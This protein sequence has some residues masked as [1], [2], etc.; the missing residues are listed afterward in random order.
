MLRALSITL[1]ALLPL[2]ACGPIPVDQAERACVETANLAL[3]PRGTVG[4]GIGSGGQVAGN[5]DVTVSTDFI[6]GRDPSAVFDSCVKSRSGQFP[7]RPLTDQPGWI[8]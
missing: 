1:F 2:A 7:T 8:G 6:T 3:R 4:V 5:L